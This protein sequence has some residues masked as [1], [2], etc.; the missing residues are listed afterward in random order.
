MCV[1][2]RTLCLQSLVTQWSLQEITPTQGTPE[3][4]RYTSSVQLL[5]AAVIKVILI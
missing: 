1:C 3:S 2:I 5:S 4:A